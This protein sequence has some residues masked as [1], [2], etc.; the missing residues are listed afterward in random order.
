M[1][2][3]PAMR[4]LKPGVILGLA[5]SLAACAPGYVAGPVYGGGYVGPAY[6]APAPRYYAPVP[7]YYAPAPRY[8]A[9]PPPR[10][11]GPPPRF[12]GPPPRYY[13]GGPYRGPYRGW[14][15]G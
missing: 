14:R 9:P 4:W 11:Y 10:F 2:E 1:L 3:E 8:Y 13:G 12:Y 7:R 6:V 15:G 5:A